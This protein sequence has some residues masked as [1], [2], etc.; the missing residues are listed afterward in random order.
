MTIAMIYKAYTGI[1]SRE[2]PDEVLDQM[3]LLGFQLGMSDWTLRSGAAPGADSAFEEGAW[4]AHNEGGPK[5][6]IYLPWHGF[7]SRGNGDVKL[8]QPSEDAFG[9]AAQFHLG[10]KYLK[11]GA[12]LLHSRNVH[13]VYGEDVLNPVLSKF[14]VCWTKNGKGQGG[15]GQAIR[16]ASANNIPVFDLYFGFEILGEYLEEIT[17]REG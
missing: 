11:R 10:W 5:P 6:E 17:A 15:T 8:T 1:G 13:Q 3:S 7:G 4:L 14:V 16:I 12:K 9:I 2:T